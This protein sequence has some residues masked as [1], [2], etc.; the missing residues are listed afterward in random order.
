MSLNQKGVIRVEMK[1]DLGRYAPFLCGEIPR[2]HADRLGEKHLYDWK[3]AEL[4][5]KLR[6]KLRKYNNETSI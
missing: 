6:E 1:E 2:T 3:A 4:C 5:E